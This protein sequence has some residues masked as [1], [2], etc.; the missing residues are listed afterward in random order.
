MKPYGYKLRDLGSSCSCCN[1]TQAK[2]YRKA[3]KKRV[4]QNIKRKIK[5]EKEKYNNN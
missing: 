4:R 1:N 3:A 2:E 5:D